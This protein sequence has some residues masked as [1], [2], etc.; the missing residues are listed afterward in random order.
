[1]TPDQRGQV[2]DRQGV[3]TIEQ[4]FDTSPALLGREVGH[5]VGLKVR[6]HDDQVTIGRPAI[7]Q[8]SPSLLHR[9]SRH[10]AVEIEHLKRPRRYHGRDHQA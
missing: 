2:V 6:R 8:Q 3:D 9:G 5:G 10:L 7:E 1:V 4:R